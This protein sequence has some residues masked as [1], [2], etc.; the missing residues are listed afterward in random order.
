MK[1]NPSSRKPFALALGTAVALGGA[2]AAQAA[3][4]ATTDLASGYQ[5]AMAGEDKAAEHK[6]GGKPDKAAEEA[7]DQT[8]DPKPQPNKHPADKAGEGKCGEGKC[9]SKPES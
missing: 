1:S 2:G 8:A 6:C 9:G 3:L 7:S 4:F 5:L